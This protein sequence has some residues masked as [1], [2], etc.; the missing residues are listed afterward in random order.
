MVGYYDKDG[1]PIEQVEYWARKY[2]EPG[3]KRVAETTLP[4]GKWVSTVWLGISYQFGTGPPLIFETVVFPSKHDWWPELDL[5]RYA[6]LAEAQDGHEK[7]VQLW[8]H[9]IDEYQDS[10]GHWHRRHHNQEG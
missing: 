5:A 8:S 9:E 4:D 7:M 10:S 2:E 1:T 3:Y 6:T